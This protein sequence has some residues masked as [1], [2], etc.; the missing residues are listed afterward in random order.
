MRKII[1][2]TFVIFSGFL[3]VLI[4]LASLRSDNTI[5]ENLT[6][7][8]LIVTPEYQ[9]TVIPST[10]I[11]DL[12]LRDNMEI[13]Q[14]DDPDSLVYMYVTVRQGNASDNTNHTW[15]EVNSFTKFFWESNSN[16][17]V[18]KAEAIVQ[19]GDENGPIPGELGYG[20]VI[21]NST[22]QI[23][24]AS[25]SMMP[26]KSYKIELRDRAG[27]WRGQ[28]TIAL[29]KH[30]FD[31]TR[32]RNK[33]LFDLMKE[34]P[35]MVSLRTQFIHL[36]V[37]DET[38]KI[39]A[40]G[41]VDYG[42]FTQIEQPNRK[43]LRNH[44]LDADGQLYK[45]TFFEFYRY[46][47]QIRLVD[48][49]LYNENLFSTI[50]E[51]K[52][53]NDHSKLI[54]MLE[55][56]NNYNIPIEQSFETYFNQENYFTWMAFNILVG[57]I[58]TQSQNFYLYSPKN[59][60]KWYFIP[61]DYDGALNRLDRDDTYPYEYWEFGL[62]N[63]WGGVL[64]NRLL[65]IDKY[66]NHLT[67]KIEELKLF[68]TPNRIES[69]LS[70]YRPIVEPFITRMPD[71]Y[72]LPGTIQ[73]F[74]AKYSQ[75][76]LEIEANYHLYYDS[77]EISMPFYLG[78]PE[79][80]GD[81]LLFKWEESYDFDAQ[82]ITYE[83]VLSKDWELREIIYSGTIQNITSYQID[84]PESGTYFW[85]V[86]ATNEDGKTQYPFDYYIDAEGMVHPGLKY[87]F[88]STEGEILEE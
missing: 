33:L 42:L 4:S 27:E 17:E 82:N 7:A 50:L 23:R 38:E 22:I 44:L 11:N 26:Q 30:I 6:L 31:I 29:N 48:D 1:S 59:S 86:M 25:T 19:I 46:L 68:L 71:I 2:I 70:M 67:E 36:F 52:G 49:P 32:V 5:N 54:R 39:P 78:T 34:I 35:N 79:I 81:K 80:I 21:P 40:V 65:R 47:E 75:M 51:I 53:N 72:Y 88:I 61:W 60:E 15:S 12:P 20:E 8:T 18:G 16:L 14:F 87:L 73:E 85:R 58:D 28:K 37:K 84:M 43:F 45:T 63:Y 62:A 13:Y 9:M 74:N 10:D 41:Y 64:H 69:M 57:N 77:L 83:F 76:P 66:R 56:V 55:D 24:G 3:F